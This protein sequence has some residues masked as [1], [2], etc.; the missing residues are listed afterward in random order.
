MTPTRRGL[1][2]GA[3][4][5]PFAPA[6][7]RAQSGFPQRPLR[8][9]VPF[10]AGGLIDVTARLLQDPL[11]QELGTNIVVENFGGAGSTI[12]AR[13]VLR[14]EPDGHT[15]LVTGAAHTVIPA[16]FPDVGFDSVN[17]FAPISLISE[18]P[19]VLCVGNNVPAN[20]VQELIAWLRTR[21]DEAT[22]ATTGIGAASHLSG[23]LF[24]NLAQVDFTFVTYRGTP[25]AVT[26]FIAGRV[27][28]MIDS[29]T[30]LAPYI[31]E[32]QIKA[33]AVTTARRSAMLPDLP[34]I[35]ESGVEGYRSSSLQM[36]L[37]RTGSPPEAIARVS[38]AVQKVMQ[39]PALQARFA[40]RG[41]EPIASDA[42][43][44]GRIIREEGE[45]WV[46]I[47]R[48]G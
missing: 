30:L 18:Q 3:S 42:A 47:L 46:P 43:A 44:L 31:R 16:L 10:N 21:G 38:E 8:M 39:D 41:I 2:A 17:D 13:Q 22:F 15:L 32:G 11:G 33:I 36:M 48:R 7:A 35:A 34:T 4:T 28:M 20:N 29:Q 9:V 24:K 23:E 12:G 27:D 26:D 14:A 40:E 6:I 37:T 19:F 45:R 5:L 25:A 1:L